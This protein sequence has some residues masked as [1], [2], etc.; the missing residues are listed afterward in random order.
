MPE[1]EKNIS[2]LRLNTGS[3]LI[4][5]P[6]SKEK[7]KVINSSFGLF[8]DTYNPIPINTNLTIDDAI[9]KPEDFLAFPFRHISAT[10]VGAWSWKATEFT[11][12]VLRKAVKLMENKPVHINH[13]MQIGSMVGGIG[14]V[15]F[16]P[17]FTAKDGTEIPGGLDAPV[18]L[19]AILHADLCRKLN[20]IPV[21]HIQS[22]SVTIAYEWEP[23]HE[24]TNRE[25]EVDEWEFI[26]RVGTEVDGDMVRRV[27]TNIIDIYESSLVALGADP[28]AKILDGEGEPIN[29]EKSAIV[30]NSKFETDP[31]ASE[32]KKT[33]R[34]FLQE[35][36]S[37]EKN[38]IDLEYQLTGKTGKLSFDKPQSKKPV[39]I[40]TS[41]MKEKILKLV[42]VKLNIE[43]S[44]V[45]EE[46]FAQFSIVKTEN[47]ATLKKDAGK[48]VKFE[49]DLATAKTDLETVTGERDKLKPNAA[50]GKSIID[51]RKEEVIRLYKLTVDEKNIDEAVITMMK[52]ADE[53]AIDG[54]MK[55][56]GKG[57]IE[58]FT[59]TCKKCNATGDDITLQSS[60]PEEGI[61]PEG[62]VDPK[63]EWTPNMSG[64]FRK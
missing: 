64:A 9:P 26:S 37:F 21:P 28:F 25:G 35:N 61:D 38:M 14:K 2:Y 11:D 3:S 18:I 46:M 8:T 49:T 10:I 60:K 17:G 31:L 52:G 43:E 62:G 57:A 32:Y 44:E 30:S 40:K 42:A 34:Y 63:E 23:S 27:V 55:Q 45:T 7:S 59:A 12:K 53:K 15:K 48:V 1:K 4:M 22:V 51:K 33:G 5:S 6:N 36:C 50:Y 47:Y 39:S 13:D 20:A 54:L 56:Y 29:V 41:T 19:D 24:F 58:K 16:T